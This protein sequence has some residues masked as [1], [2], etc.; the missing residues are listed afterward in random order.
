MKIGYSLNNR[1]EHGNRKVQ[2]NSL[3]FCNKCYM[4]F[5][6]EPYEI[7]VCNGIDVNWNFITEIRKSKKKELKTSRKCTYV[8]FL[9]WRANE[10]IN[11][12]KQNMNGLKHSEDFRPQTLSY[13]IVRIQWKNNE[14]KKKSNPVNASHAHLINHWCWFLWFWTLIELEYRLTKCSLRVPFFILSLSLFILCVCILRKFIVA[15]GSMWTAANEWNVHAQ[16]WLFMV[17]WTAWK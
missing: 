12:T 15:L 2:S 5:F 6:R 7:F 13:H 1:P 11:F 16:R 3:R 8:L 17:T 10:W 14:K 4:A 9:V